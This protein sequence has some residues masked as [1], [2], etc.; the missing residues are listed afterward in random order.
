MTVYKIIGLNVETVNGNSYETE[1]LNNKII[2]DKTTGKGITT[3][4]AFTR[5][6]MYVV[7]EN[8]YYAIHLYAA[9]YASSRG[10]L[11]TI[12]DMSTTLSNCD[13]SMANITHVPLTPVGFKLNNYYEDN[14]S[15]YV[16]DDPDTW[17]FKYS[18]DGDDERT[19]AGFVNVNMELFIPK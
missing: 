17:V 11:C 12:G 3:Q 2:H 7:S 13:E 14:V 18:R 8:A 1:T 9:H 5:Y 6:T 15:V 10:R 4:R 19:P 16:D